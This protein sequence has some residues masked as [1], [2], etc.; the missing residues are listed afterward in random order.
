MQSLEGQLRFDLKGML[1]EYESRTG[2]RPS[3]SDLSRATGISADTLK[4]LASR[5]GYNTT[6]ETISKV[7]AHLSLDPRPYLTWSE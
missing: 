6:L 1:D 5:L 2:L 7:A 3:Y 4:S